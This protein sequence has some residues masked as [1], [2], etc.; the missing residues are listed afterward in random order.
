[1]REFGFGGKKSVYI[2]RLAY[3]IILADYHIILA[4]CHLLAQH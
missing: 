3:H 2:S 4:D 1:M